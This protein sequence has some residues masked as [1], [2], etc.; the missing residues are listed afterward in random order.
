[1]PV[2]FCTSP[3]DAMQNENHVQEPL[4]FCSRL[5]VRDHIDFQLCVGAEE[6]NMCKDRFSS[7]QCYISV[8]RNNAIYTRYRGSRFAGN[9]L[10][11][12]EKMSATTVCRPP[13]AEKVRPISPQF[14]SEVARTACSTAFLN[15]PAE[16]SV[17]FSMFGTV[18]RYRPIVVS[19]VSIGAG[20]WLIVAPPSCVLS[21]DRGS[22][23]HNMYKMLAAMR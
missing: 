5:D 15:L 4:S 11:Y 2:P 18:H 19:N 6:A 7:P 22:P 14:S 17:R 8:A 1:M 13:E 12:V 16:L 3:S 21:S 10:A 9:I 23:K 20:T